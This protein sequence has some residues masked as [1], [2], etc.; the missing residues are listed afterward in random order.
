MGWKAEPLLRRRLK[1]Y[2][3]EALIETGS[4]A[5]GMFLAQEHLSPPGLFIRLLAMPFLVVVVKLIWSIRLATGYYCVRGADVATAI[6][7]MT[8]VNSRGFWSC[9][10]ATLTCLSCVLMV[11]HAIMFLLMTGYSGEVMS[12]AE[13]HTVKYILASSAIFVVVN[14][15][16]WRDFVNHYKEMPEEPDDMKLL[17]QIV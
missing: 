4:V 3:A 10:A 5:L 16:L 1:I 14:W 12:K 2:I 11:W 8:P 9:S 15:A 17:Y 7:K 13:A 6:S